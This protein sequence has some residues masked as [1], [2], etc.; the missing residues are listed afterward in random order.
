[1]MEPMVAQ[2]FAMSGA[3][4]GEPSREALSAMCRSYGL[5]E[6]AKA[7]SVLGVPYAHWKAPEGDEMFLTG[8]GISCAASL[9]PEKFWTDA[10]WFSSHSRRLSGS[11]TLY[12]ITTKPW[13]GIS[14]EIVLK[15]NRMGQE[16]PWGN[17][18]DGSSPYEFNSPY[19][20]FSLVMELRGSRGETSGHTITHRPLAIYV[21]AKF[22]RADRSGRKDYLMNPKIVSH[23][24]VKLDILRNYAVIYEWMEGI[25]AAEAYKRDLLEQAEMEQLVLGAEEELRTRGFVVG[26]SKAHHL[27]VRSNDRGRLI[28]DRQGR[29][30]YGLVDFELL[31][32]TPQREDTLRKARRHAYLRKQK[33]RFSRPANGSQRLAPGMM[34]TSIAGVDYVHAP[35]RST[36]GALWVAGK[37]PSLFDYFLPERWES[38]PRTRLSERHGVFYTLTKDNIHLVWKASKAGQK[39]DADPFDA[40]GQRILEHGYNSP[41]EEFALAL[42]LSRRGVPTVNPRAIYMG[43]RHSHTP[44]DLYDDNRYQSHMKL[45]TWDG[46]PLLR[47]D[48]DYFLIW[49]YWNGPDDKLAAADGDYYESLSAQRAYRRG[50]IDKQQYLGLMSRYK[51]MLAEA[52][53]EDLNLRGSHLLLSLRSSGELVRDALG[54]PEVRVCN[55]ELLRKT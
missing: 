25:D 31:A 17:V 32:R 2:F 40:K 21:P 45:V 23:K 22:V 1:M 11:S 9:R 49:G 35:V 5:P 27:I 41:F 55:F 33:D 48:R 18:A 16:V 54:E 34:L 50:I 3:A 8:Y 26:D 52:R 38:T 14:K 30:P 10:D 28:R 44:E 20:E 36:G 6:N 19:E 7:V 12:K 24:E 15:W 29:V 51:A 39:P 53:V 46:S 4:P 37:D 13:R 42:E 47:R 43:G